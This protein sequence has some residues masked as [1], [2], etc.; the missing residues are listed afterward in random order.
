MHEGHAKFGLRFM[1]LVLLT[2]VI[3]IPLLKVA[4]SKVELPESVSSWILSI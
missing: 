1:L 4:V 2:V 3:L